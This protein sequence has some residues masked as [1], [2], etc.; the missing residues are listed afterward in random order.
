MCSVAST[1]PT[2]RAASQANSDPDY[3]FLAQGSGTAVNQILATLPAGTLSPDT[4]LIRIKAT[5]DLTAYFGFVVAVGLEELD[6]RP[7]IEI[8]SPGKY[9]DVP[10]L[11]ASSSSA[12][13]IET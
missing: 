9:T 10:R 6:I 4:Y 8:T 1:G 5:G 13:S 11:R 2:F 12:E 7:G 3:I